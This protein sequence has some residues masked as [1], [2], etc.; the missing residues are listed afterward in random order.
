M[1]IELKTK[2]TQRRIPTQ[3]GGG[4]NMMDATY[5]PLSINEDYFFPNC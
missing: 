2:Y 1:L 4:S 5:N 3:G